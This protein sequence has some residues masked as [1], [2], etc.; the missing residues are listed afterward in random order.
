MTSF[1]CP[2]WPACGCPDGTIA[3]DCPGVSRPAPDYSNEEE[4]EEQAYD[5]ADA[6][7]DVYGCD[8]SIRDR[9]CAAFEDA[10]RHERK[11]RAGGAETIP[12]ADASVQPS[13]SPARQ[14]SPA[15]Q[16]ILVHG[17]DGLTASSLMTGALLLDNYL[18][19]VTLP[20][21]REAQLT[22]IDNWR[23]ALTAVARA[24]AKEG[25]I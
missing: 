19:N 8:S 6:F 20:G 15:G 21:A 13:A 22:D 9:L 14:S 10:I 1:S 3:D 18:I 24:L 2:L 11:K 12:T 17:V 23:K 5:Y 7:S 4:I 25:L 16:G